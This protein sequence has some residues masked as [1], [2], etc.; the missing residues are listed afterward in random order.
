MLECSRECK[1]ENQA[2]KREIK[3]AGTLQEGCMDNNINKMD[4]SLTDMLSTLCNYLTMDYPIVL[5]SNTS[6]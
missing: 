1:V 3:D 2:V 4:I 5:I 6:G